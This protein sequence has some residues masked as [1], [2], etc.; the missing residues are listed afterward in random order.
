[1]LGAAAEAWP[2]AAAEAIALAI[3]SLVAF[4]DLGRP[5][6]RSGRRELFVPLGRGAYVIQ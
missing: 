4:P 3:E 5:M 2:A 6:L 1:M